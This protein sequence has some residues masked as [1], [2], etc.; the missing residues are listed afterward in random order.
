[1]R[2]IEI[3]NPTAAAE[4][5]GQQLL[6]GLVSHKLSWLLQRCLQENIHATKATAP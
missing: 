6:S 4:A 3:K 1:M 2:N 5:A